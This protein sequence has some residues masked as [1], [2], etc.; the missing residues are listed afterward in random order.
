M[1]VYN[2]F[3]D[4]VCNIY[5]QSRKNSMLTK[6]ADRDGGSTVKNKAKGV[7]CYPLLLQCVQ[8]YGDI[9]ISAWEWLEILS[10]IQIFHLTIKLWLDNGKQNL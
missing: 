10:N 8:L 2:F 1:K 7:T 6:L 5:Q 9:I 3:I 4:F